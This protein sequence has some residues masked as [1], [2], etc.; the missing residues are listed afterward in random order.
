MEPTMLFAEFVLGM[1]AVHLISQ[2]SEQIAKWWA[3]NRPEHASAEKNVR[4]DWYVFFRCSDLWG[5]DPGKKLNQTTK[6]ADKAQSRRDI[7]PVARV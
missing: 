4:D 1:C 7:R 5:K 2:S 6:P 3:R